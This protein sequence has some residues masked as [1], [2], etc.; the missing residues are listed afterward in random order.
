[1][2]WDGRGVGMEPRVITNA[3]DNRAKQGRRK[4]RCMRD[5]RGTTGEMTFLWAA[6]E[7]Q[8]DEPTIPRYG[9]C[10]K[11]RAAGAWYRIY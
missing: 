9:S 6:I 8:I 11:C 5:W 4:R 2:V 1:M 10:P 7:R 3:C